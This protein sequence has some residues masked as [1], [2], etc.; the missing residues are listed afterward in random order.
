[1]SRGTLTGTR[2]RER[3]T[4]IGQK[5]A[6]LARNVGISPS[7][8]NL[9]E[10]NRRRIG[11]K[12]LIDIA[13]QLKVDASA[14]AEGAGAAL[15]EV[16]RD[17]ASGDSNAEADLTRMEE[18][19]G[20]FPGWAQLLV[21]QH[22]RVT[23]L[24][25]TVEMLTDRMTHDPFLS[26]SLHEV[27]ST[28]TAIR[29]TAS[30][31]AETDDIDREWQ[32]RFHRNMHD[33][34]QRLAESARALVTYLDE[35]GEDTLMQGSPQEEV[36]AFLKA[37]NYHMPELEQRTP[38]DISD[39]VKAA[40]E[41][42]SAPARDL[43]LKFLTRYAQ[44]AQ[45]MPLTTFSAAA[46]AAKGEPAQ[47]AA[48]FNIDLASVFRRL[49]SLPQEVLGRPVGLVM[50]D[51]S[52]T[53]TFRKAVDGFALPRF[54]AACPLWPLY[55]SLARPMVPIRRTIELS[56]RA[57]QVFTAYAICQSTQPAGFDAP[58]ILEAS[59]LFSPE[60]SLAET[61]QADPVGTSCRI[62]VRR[63]CVARREQSIMAD[64]F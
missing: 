12:L 35:S 62:C 57:Q 7:Y 5:Q 26:A 1:M 6:D 50:C 43:A 29:S 32:D 8:L 47:L 46:Q 45:A 16:L 56:T 4:M 18:F 21:N 17:V 41:L 30:I 23:D 10:H 34:S 54:G 53:L 9:I 55:Q 19:A 14:L 20:R 60:A 13:R 42:Q 44:D 48:Q 27:L 33:E 24:E 40:A 11:G 3:R 2:I 61:V 37:R 58:Q 31:L 49:A 15:L 59:M 22:R 36:E 28:V 52:G 39:I 38:K 25:R 63:D 64:G 51:G